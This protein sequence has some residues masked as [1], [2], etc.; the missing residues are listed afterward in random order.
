MR[1]IIIKKNKKL[2]RTVGVPTLYD[3]SK[4]LELQIQSLKFDTESL[5]LSKVQH[6]CDNNFSFGGSN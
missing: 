3:K 2:V 4:E 5:K 6:K 1:S